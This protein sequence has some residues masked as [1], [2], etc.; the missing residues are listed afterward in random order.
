MWA[1]KVVHQDQDGPDQRPF[2]TLSDRS[3]NRYNPH[4]RLYV[5]RVATPTRDQPDGPVQQHFIHRGYTTT[6]KTLYVRH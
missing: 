6:D 3:G 4:R 1:T 2:Q 5:G